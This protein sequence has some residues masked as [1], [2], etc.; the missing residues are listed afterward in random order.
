MSRTI[1]IHD[2]Q[3]WWDLVV[4]DILDEKGEPTGH[5]HEINKFP[6]SISGIF[7]DPAVYNEFIDNLNRWRYET[8]S[9]FYVV[10][11]PDKNIQEIFTSYSLEPDYPNLALAVLNIIKTIGLPSAYELLEDDNTPSKNKWDFLLWDRETLT[12][13]HAYLMV[14][15]VTTFA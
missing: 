4:E 14:K 3:E 1:R 13:V 8:N 10:D 2:G 5:Y 9:P 15:E 7:D 12:M 6:V 11:I